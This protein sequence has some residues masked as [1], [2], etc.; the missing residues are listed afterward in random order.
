[1]RGR[2]TQIVVLSL[3][4]LW[5][6]SLRAQSADQTVPSGQRSCPTSA[7]D[8]CAPDDDQPPGPEISIVKVNFLGT[9]QLPVADQQEIAASIKQTARGNVLDGLT[10][11]ALERVR[12]GWQDHGYFKVEV[13]GG[14]KILSSSPAAQRLVLDV[15]IDEGPQYR[16]GEIRF[17]YNNGFRDV[18]ALRAVFPIKD[19]DIFSR[20]AIAAGL[21]NLRKAYGELG[22]INFTAAPDTEF[23]DEDRLIHLKIDLDEGELFHIGDVTVLGLDESAQRELMSS[24]GLKRGEVYNQ[25]LWEK[26]LLKPSGCGS[27]SELDAKTGTIN[28]VLDCRPS[29][30]E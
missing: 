19:G 7:P 15:H 13:S 5:A 14:A 20:D 26:L 30:R 27:E 8:A 22:Y 6:V 21:E 9:L 25:S 16:L 23:D 17:E 18:G 24:T 29:S 3:A 12:A 1:M 4:A 11:E 28:I 2:R 10:D